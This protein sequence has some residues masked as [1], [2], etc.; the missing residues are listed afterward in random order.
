MSG[1][2]ITELENKVVLVEGTN[3]VGIKKNCLWGNKGSNIV[4]KGSKDVNVEG[5][6]IQDVKP[7]NFDEDDKKPAGILVEQS[8]NTLKDNK[9]RTS[10]DGIK[11]RSYKNKAFNQI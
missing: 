11:I 4:L 2:F 9:V 5:N 3:Q 7:S 6:T 1:N 10:H 8:A